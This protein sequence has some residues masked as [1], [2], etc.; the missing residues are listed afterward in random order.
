MVTCS[1]ASQHL[2]EDALHCL[3]GLPSEGVS[4]RKP[5]SPLLLIQLVCRLVSRLGD[6]LFSQLASWLV[7]WLVGR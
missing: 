6:C 7:G 1:S 4:P 3:L 2:P 5:W